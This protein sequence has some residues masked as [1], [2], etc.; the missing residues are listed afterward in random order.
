MTNGVEDPWRWASL[1]KSQGNIISRV[2]DCTNCAHCVDLYTPDS[3]DAPELKKIR[4][5]EYLSI[6]DWLGQSEMVAE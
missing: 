1:Q 5:E 4:D 3:K 2:A 6:L